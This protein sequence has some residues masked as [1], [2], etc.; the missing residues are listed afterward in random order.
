MI[1]YQSMANFSKELQE[2]HEEL[3]LACGDEEFETGSVPVTSEIVM[4][5]VDIEEFPF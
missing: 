5:L 3:T 1:P 2:F 4:P